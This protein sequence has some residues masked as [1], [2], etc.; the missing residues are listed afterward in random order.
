M[1][2]K[3]MLSLLTLTFF[4]LPAA[5]RPPQPPKGRSL[6]TF[7]Q[8][9]RQE[10]IKQ[11][12]EDQE[13]KKATKAGSM[14]RLGTDACLSTVKALTADSIYETL[15]NVKRYY[16]AHPPSQSSVVITK[17]ILSHLID[18]YN[19]DSDWLQKIVNDLQKLPTM[20]VFKNPEMQAWI[21]QQIERRDRDEALILVAKNL[22]IQKINELLA[23][24]V[25]ANAK[26]TWSNPHA[27]VDTPLASAFTHS[28]QYQ[29][30]EEQKKLAEVVQLLLKAGAD[31]NGTKGEPLYYAVDRGLPSFVKLLL[32]AGADSRF[33]KGLL[34]AAINNMRQ[35][36]ERWQDYKEILKMLLEAGADPNYRS[37]S[38]HQGRPMT[39]SISIKRLSDLSYNEKTE[40]IELLKQY[41]LKE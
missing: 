2:M 17:A 24:G 36:K 29:T 23:Q 21:K 12:K 27:G 7:G 20:T 28:Y 33:F 16:I 19:L 30:A 6:P 40:L 10:E 13:R 14:E 34:W 15:K 32:D 4:S 35:R 3:Q 5:E 11:K 39:L 25:S 8:V 22:D 37:S 9:V 41:G 18:T 26:V 1:R 38:T 31:V